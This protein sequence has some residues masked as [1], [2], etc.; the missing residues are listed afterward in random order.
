MGTRY[1]VKNEDSESYIGVGV[2][3]NVK[4][5]VFCKQVNFF[6]SRLFKSIEAALESVNRFLVGNI[7]VFEITAGSLVEVCV[8]DSS[9]D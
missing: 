9:K 3:D 5:P 6:H 1:I 7:R 8:Y 2:V 4:T